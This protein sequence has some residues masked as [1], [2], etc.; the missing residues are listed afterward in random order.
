ML[1]RFY[2][3][4]QYNSFKHAMLCGGVKNIYIEGSQY[5]DHRGGGV[6]DIVDA[7]GTACDMMEHKAVI[8]YFLFDDSGN[9]M[10]AWR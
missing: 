3:D 9:F 7:V 1:L 5:E 2:R 4:D 10:D 8:C 6:A